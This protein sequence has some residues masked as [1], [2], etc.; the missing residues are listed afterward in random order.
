MDMEYLFKDSE[1]ISIGKPQS[2]SKKR[3]R[4]LGKTRDGKTLRIILWFDENDNIIYSTIL[5]E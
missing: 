2:F 1:G 4:K 5:K 3:E